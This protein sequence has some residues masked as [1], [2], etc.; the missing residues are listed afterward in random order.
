MNGKLKCFISILLSFIM[1]I[2]LTTTVSAVEPR[3][4]GTHSATVKLVFSGTTASCDVRIT[5][6]D[7]TT[8]IT[9]V[10]ITLKDS[11]NNTVGEWRN[12]SSPNNR[13]TFYDTV[14]N[15]T[16]GETYTLSFTATI[17]KDLGTESISGNSTVT[18]PSK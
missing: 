9:D 4:L 17:N 1:I 14:T 7:G 6:A 18:C 16:K 12:L 13:F 5:G 2:G 11:K 8:S 3:Y 10:N 15:L